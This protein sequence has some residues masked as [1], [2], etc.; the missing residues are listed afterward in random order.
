[1]VPGIPW[2]AR[3]VVYPFGVGARG[4]EGGEGER[5]LGQDDGVGNGDGVG[6]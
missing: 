2:L 1:M 6:A 5:G 3:R 4:K